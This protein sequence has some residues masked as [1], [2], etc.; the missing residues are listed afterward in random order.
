M[1]NGMLVEKCVRRKCK[2]LVKPK[3]IASLE[4]DLKDADLLKTYKKKRGMLIIH[5]NA[6]FG[7]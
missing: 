7:S 2:L 3:S 1:L 4:S 5:W 6:K